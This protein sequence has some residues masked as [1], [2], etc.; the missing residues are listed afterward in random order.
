[1]QEK[2]K[3]AQK[4]YRDRQASCRAQCVHVRMPAKAGEAVEMCERHP[5]WVMRRCPLL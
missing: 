1:M 5:R 3:V 4:R 2:N